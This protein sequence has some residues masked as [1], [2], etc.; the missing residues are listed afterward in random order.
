MLRL[1]RDGTMTR[2][3]FL[4]TYLTSYTGSFCWA[5]SLRELE[6]LAI[7]DENRS[8]SAMA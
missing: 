2:Y 7:G 1:W 3:S 5:K 8:L 6:A 4:G